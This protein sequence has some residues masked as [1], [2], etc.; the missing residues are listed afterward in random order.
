MPRLSRHQQ[1][2]LLIVLSAVCFGFLPIFGSIA[3]RDGADAQAILLLRFGLSGSLM[4]LVMLTGRVR[5]PKGKLLLGLAA[6][7]GAGYVGQAYCY[8][9]ALHFASAALA[10][11]LLYLYP[12]MVTL[13]SA[14]FLKERIT[15]R[16]WLALGVASA[17]LLLTLGNVGSG[18]WLGIVFGI[19]AA[20]IY[21]FYILAGSRLSPRAGAL[22][23]AS[24]VMLSAF[25][26]M[27][28]STA[29][30]T[31]AWPHSS[32][33]WLAILAIALIS[34]VVAIFSFLAGL[35][36]LSAAEASTLSTLEPVVSVILASTLL[37]DPI[38]ATQ[39]LGGVAIIAAALM[40]AL[41]PARPIPE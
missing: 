30:H 27:A 12:I 25:A 17:G 24:V 35:D 31:P 33:G 20:A 41:K 15:R 38:A 8:F 23:A 13:L 21:S 3:Y 4:L 26:S 28:T 9:S 5:W 34:T 6:M 36:R 10:A 29:F 32:T 22:P 11:L 14:L 7:G 40:I 16:G 1:G 2:L 37:G 39:W 19:S 18:Q